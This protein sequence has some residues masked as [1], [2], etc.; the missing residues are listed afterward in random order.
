MELG[1]VE[2]YADQKLGGQGVRALRD[3]HMPRTKAKQDQRNVMASISVVAADL[4]CA[5][6]ECVVDKNS[7]ADA[8]PTYHLQLDR[9]RVFELVIIGS[10]KSITCPTGC[11]T[12]GSPALAT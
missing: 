1:W 4:H 5:G 3:I 8:D 9:Q 11:A 7:T 12:S 10:G 2:I 6:P